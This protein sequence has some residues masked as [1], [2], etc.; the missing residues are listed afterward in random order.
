MAN[1][2]RKT[3][4]HTSLGQYWAICIAEGL[5][6]FAY[7][8]CFSEATLVAESI[9]AFLEISPQVVAVIPIGP[10]LF[11]TDKIETGDC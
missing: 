5:V 1:S 10:R 2:Y 8:H 9:L 6:G 11:V 3:D 4:K 7:A